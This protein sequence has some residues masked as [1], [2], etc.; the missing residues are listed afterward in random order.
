MDA[1]F[2]KAPQGY[3]AEWFRFDNATAQSTR[4]GE[5]AGRTTRLEAP[6]SLPRHDGAFVHVKVSS[7]GALKPS[8]EKPMDVF[9]RYEQ[10]Q[11][12]LVGVDRMPS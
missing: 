4:I 1:D 5:T 11:W 10:G 9:F 2:A 7:V 8:W 12:H 3:R 6:S